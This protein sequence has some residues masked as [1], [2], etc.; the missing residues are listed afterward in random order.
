MVGGGAG[1][2]RTYSGVYA[3]CLLGD[4]VATDCSRLFFGG[5]VLP[6]LAAI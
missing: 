4:E 3:A 2:E 6:C 5:C 1:R